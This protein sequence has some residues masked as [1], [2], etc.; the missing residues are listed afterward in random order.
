MD[1]YEMGGIK[2][3]FENFPDILKETKDEKGKIKIAI[4]FGSGRF[5]GA[6]H[7]GYITD[8]L[9]V[10]EIVIGLNY[11]AIKNRCDLIIKSHLDIDCD[12]QEYLTE[13]NFISI[14]SGRV[15]KVSKMVQDYFGKGLKVRFV[16][17][18]APTIV[19]DLSGFV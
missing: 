3:D 6:N 1:P 10:P 17:P 11:W 12:N 13:Y 7:I 18:N 5:T 19:S 9:F 8:A 2:L 4:V 16:P 15:N 14:G